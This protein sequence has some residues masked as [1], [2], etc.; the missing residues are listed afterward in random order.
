MNIIQIF[1][2][3]AEWG[4]WSTCLCEEAN[5][6]EGTRSSSR[7]C[8]NPYPST[9]EIPCAGDST[10]TEGCPK[11]CTFGGQISFYLYPPLSR[12][13]HLYYY[14]FGSSGSQIE[15]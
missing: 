6:S 8:P 13:Y 11:D 3:W 10:R 12:Y 14:F 4:P 2:D 5:S 9:G 7:T 15:E 1:K